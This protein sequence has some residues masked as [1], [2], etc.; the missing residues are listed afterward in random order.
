[1]CQDKYLAIRALKINV[2]IGGSNMELYDPLPALK[3]M[4][5]LRFWV[6]M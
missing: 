3:E 6:L 2:K 5:M 4:V 1:M